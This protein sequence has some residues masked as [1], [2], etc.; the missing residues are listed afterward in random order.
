MVW[1]EQASINGLKIT[2]G[3]K[4]TKFFATT[5]TAV[6]HIIMVSVL[7]KK[8]FNPLGAGQKGPQIFPQGDATQMANRIEDVR[9]DY[10]TVPQKEWVWVDIPA[11]TMMG[12]MFPTPRINSHE[13]LPGK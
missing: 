11:E 3:L 12:D 6:Q 8:N 1:V 2:T 7:T 13:Y 10:D 4:D 9:D 5:A